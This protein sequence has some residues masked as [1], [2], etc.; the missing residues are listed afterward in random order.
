MDENSNPYPW[1]EQLPPGNETLEQGD[2][3][4]D[5]S[6]VLPPTELYEGQEIDITIQ[7]RDVI[8]LSQSCDL[9]NG[10]IDRV[11]VCPYFGIEQYWSFFGS[12]S[13]KDKKSMLKKLQQSGL[14]GAHLLHPLPNAKQP[15]VVDFRNI[16]GIPFPYLQAYCASMDR[17]RL[18]P[19]YKEHLSQAFARYFM[20]V[21]L[22]ASI[23]PYEPQTQ[24]RP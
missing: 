24:T 19:P 17:Y 8:I 7:K 5:C 23:P 9:E 10:K 21:G 12:L 18:L 2:F 20:R 3:A 14:P 15:I 1:Y 13:K 6:I 4:P 16:Y 22:P 11:M